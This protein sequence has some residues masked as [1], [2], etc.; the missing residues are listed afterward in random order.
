MEL[1]EEKEGDLK[2]KGVVFLD[3]DGT[4]NEDPGYLNDPEAVKLFDGVPEALSLL[5][6]AGFDLVVV[7]NQSGIARGIIN[8]QNLVLINE[9]ING[10]V[11]E[12]KTEISKFML[13]VH[14]P[15]DRC[16]CRKPQP[17]LLLEYCQSKGI[18]PEHCYM[19]GDKATDLGA[20]RNAGCRG[21]ALV[22]TGYGQEE[23]GSL[24]EGEADFVGADLLEVSHWILKDSN[25]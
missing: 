12:A 25:F 10:L 20:G 1:G 18:Q 8:P 22:R 14:H 15:D 24:K 21:V 23:E 19:V 6:Q 11:S 13:C 3:R 7:S 2:V 4:L 5:S 9:R 17:K 16:D